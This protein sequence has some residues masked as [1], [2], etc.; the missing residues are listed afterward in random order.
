M[1]AFIEAVDAARLRLGQEEGGGEVSEREMLRRA[2]K[3]AGVEDN[4]R[5]GASYH[6]NPNRHDGSKPHQVPAWLV[7]ALEGVLPVARGELAQA[8]RVAAGFTAVED[9]PGRNVTYM[10]QRFY[11]DEDI[12]EDERAQVTSELLQILA[13]V[14]RRQNTRGAYPP[15]ADDDGDGNGE[16]SADRADATP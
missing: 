5:P 7:D 9:R 3:F 1:D 16:P 2:F 4:K 14:T 11:G 8:A 10:V 15:T 13:E 6:L 12:G